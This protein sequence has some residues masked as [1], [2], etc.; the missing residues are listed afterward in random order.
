MKKI[1]NLLIYLFIAIGTLLSTAIFW[2]LDTWQNLSIDEMLY[3][4]QAPKEGTD[5][6]IIVGFVMKSLLPTLAVFLLVL[7]LTKIWK[8]KKMLYG[9]LFLGATVVM[10]VFSVLYV[11][12]KLDI[13]NYRKNGSMYSTLID[14]NYV[15]PSQVSVEFPEKKRNL[16][17]I[18]MESMENTFADAPVGGA[19]EENLIP[20]LTKLALEN[21]SFGEKSG[22]L[23]GG[24]VLNKGTYT[25]GALFSQSMGLPLILPF[26]GNAMSSQ[27]SFMP[28]LCGL[29]D[30]LE[31]AGYQNTLLIGSEAVFGGRELFYREHG[32]YEILD[33]NAAKE[34]GEIP[35]DHYVFWGYEDWRMF[36]IGK[37]TLLEKAKSEEPFNLTMLT[38]DTHFEDGYV[39]EYCEPVHGENVYADVYQCAD[40]QISEFVRWIQEQD[41]YDNTTIVLVGDHLTMDSDFCKDVEESYERKVF[42]TIINGASEPLEKV[43]RKYS[44]LDM[45]PTTLAALGVKIEGNRLGLGTNLYSEEPTLLERYEIAEVNNAFDQKSVMMEYLNAGVDWENSEEIH[46][47]Q[48]YYSAYQFAKEREILM[49]NGSQFRAE[50][51]V[52]RSVVLEAL[53]QLE[54]KPKAG[55]H[56]ARE[57]FEDVKGA[58]YEKALNWACQNGIVTDE[59]GEGMFRGNEPITREALVTMLYRYISYKNLDCTQ[60]SSLEGFKN[61]EMLS[62]WAKDGMQ[63]AVGVKIISG[64]NGYDLAPQGVVTRAQAATMFMRMCETYGL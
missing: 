53:Y 21:E 30:I 49:E 45:F 51:Q 62:A 44:T 58:S 3:H 31:D 19:F 38:V 13:G 57:L 48:W 6:A 59:T 5:A 9:Y 54:G 25:M 20:N 29:G 26:D 52:Q 23:N 43:E 10:T 33:Y 61:K 41:F 28:E 7:F 36:E 24:V 39:C 12:K 50:Q 4:L 55:R 14:D 15:Y 22:T 32:N 8:K 34:R 46:K 35:A 37:K 1:G 40:R 42:T 18:F 63:W 16:V 60:K 27:E 17:Y 56:V 11:W 2:M 64:L 47:E